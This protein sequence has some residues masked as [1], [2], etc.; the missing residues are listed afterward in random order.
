M[1]LLFV[2]LLLLY[3]L[4]VIYFLVLPPLGVSNSIV[5]FLS[6]N[7]GV[8]TSISTKSLSFVRPFS[9]NSGITLCLFVSFF[10]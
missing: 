5:F 10:C 3:V 1:L 4:V 2:L 9:G 7:F 6:F 8:T